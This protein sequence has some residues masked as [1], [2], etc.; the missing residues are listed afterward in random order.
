M[1][2]CTITFHLTGDFSA[3][4]V[5]VLAESPVPCV[6]ARNRE[7]TMLRDLTLVCCLYLKG[8]NNLVPRRELHN[9]P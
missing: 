5:D 3:E 7:L 8:G 6:R 1:C 2:G 4:P 9:L